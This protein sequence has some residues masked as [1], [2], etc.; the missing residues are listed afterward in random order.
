L[1][2]SPPRPD[3]E[4]RV[5][6]PSLNVRAGAS[7]PLTVYALRKDGFS[8]EIAL[9][10][11]DAPPGFALSGSRVPANQD[12][13]RL[14]LKAPPR[15][16]QHPLS[17]SIEGRVTL[18]GREV[19]RP[20]VPAEDMM[21]AFIYR[22]LVPAN[23]LRVAVIHAAT[24]PPQGREAVQNLPPQR[25]HENPRARSG[26]DLGLGLGG[27]SADCKSTTSLR[28]VGAAVC[29]GRAPDSALDSSGALGEQVFNL[30]GG[31]CHHL[32]SPAFR[33]SISQEDLPRTKSR[34]LRPASLSVS[35]LAVSRPRTCGY[36]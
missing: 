20:A 18:Q 36:H 4:L 26:P 35:R 31:R 19:R 7:V 15:P 17:L 32:F 34:A 1:R 9:T 2:I 12:Q 10:L 5:V 23:E 29:P 16:L 11:K 22:H 13:V 14:T 30:H 33:N 8:N 3:F 21:Q 6:P 24:P 28:Y 27:C 25:P